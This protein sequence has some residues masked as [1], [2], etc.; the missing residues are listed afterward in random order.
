[1]NDCGA[2]RATVE[3]M[4]SIGY[5]YDWYNEPENIKWKT[6]DYDGYIRRWTDEP[7]L[8][9]SDCKKW[10]CDT[11]NQGYIKTNNICEDWYES[12]ESR[13]I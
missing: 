5:R 13:P 4:L 3:D 8:P 10:D 2:K 1:M 7:F 11:P 6:T 9:D 12:K